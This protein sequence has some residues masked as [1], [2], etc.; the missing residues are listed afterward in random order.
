MSE[1]GMTRT[2]AYRYINRLVEVKYLENTA[3]DARPFLKPG[4]NYGEWPENGNVPTSH[5]RP[6]ERPNVR[7]SPPLLGGGRQDETRDETP[8]LFADAST[9]ENES[10]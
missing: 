8:D 7:P 9:Q 3:S 6:T 2:S 4:V 5:P 1:H 10:K